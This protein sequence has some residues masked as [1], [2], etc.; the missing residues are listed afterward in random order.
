MDESSKYITKDKLLTYII[1][2][3]VIGFIIG[4]IYGERALRM[5]VEKQILK[6]V[7]FVSSDPTS[8]ADCMYQKLGW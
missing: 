7:D 2:F 6:C 1:P 3:L 8:Y 5:R 4:V